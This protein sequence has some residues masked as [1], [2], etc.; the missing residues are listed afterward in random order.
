MIPIINKDIFESNADIIVHQVNCQGVMNSGIA[1]QVRNKYPEVYLSY[2]QKCKETLNK[3]TLLGEAQFCLILSN[4]INSKYICNLFGQANYGYNGLYTNYNA[5]RKGFKTINEQ[6]K[7]KSIA[8][9]YLMSCVRGGGDW[10]VVSKIIEEELKDYD[11]SFYKYNGDY[12]Y[13]GR[14]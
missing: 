13:K 1:K 7:G 10:E 11:V 4:N 6:C 14:K 12:K 3:E 9:P 2:M 5:L 8:I